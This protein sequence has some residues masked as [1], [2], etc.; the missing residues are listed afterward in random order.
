MAGPGGSLA[1]L[2]V[3]PTRRCNLACGHCYTQSGPDV[4]ETLPTDLLVAAVRDAAA[5]GYGELAVSGGEPLLY[6][7]LTDLLRAGREAGMVNVVTTNAMPLTERR[8]FELAPLV[9]VVAVSIDGTPEHHDRLRG[10]SGAH[11]TTV[12]HLA[13]L[14]AA[15]IPFGIITTLTQHNVDQLAA[16]ARL[17]AQEGAALLQVHPLDQQGRAVAALPGA[18]PDAMELVAA[19]VEGVRLRSGLPLEVQV[20]ALLRDDLAANPER[21]YASGVPGSGRL[22][23]WLQTLVVEASGRVV[24]LT[25]GFPAALALGDLRG[26]PLA[27]LAAWWQANRAW[28]FASVLRQAYGELT[29]TEA[30]PVVSW[31]EAVTAIATRLVGVRVSVGTRRGYADLSAARTPFHRSGSVL[32]GA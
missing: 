9:D 21:F 25:H 23:D 28:W 14:R 3:H 24:P 30:P 32:Y 26:A 29:A 4:D 15:G 5:L 18:S 8:A 16:V 22:G 11:A 2:Q 1:T 6:A 20:D 27:E 17:A 7:G 12:R 10:R 31:Y 19:L 13:H